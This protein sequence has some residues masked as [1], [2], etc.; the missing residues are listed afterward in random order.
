MHK[1][2]EIVNI[3]GLLVLTVGYLD[4]TTYLPTKFYYNI[5]SVYFIY[6]L[7]VLFVST[8]IY[9]IHI[10]YI[11]IYVH[12]YIHTYTCICNIFIYIYTHLYTLYTYIYFYIQHH[13]GIRKIVFKPV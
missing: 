3:Q 1:S 9:Y 13:G 5:E 2:K 12:I 10:H 8:Y 4:M 11:N 6:R 7:F